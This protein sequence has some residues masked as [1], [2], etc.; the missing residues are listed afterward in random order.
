MKVRCLPAASRGRDLTHSCIPVH[1]MPITSPFTVVLEED[2]LRRVS[3]S[4]MLIG[5]LR[6]LIVDISTESVE[7]SS[8]MPQPDLVNNTPSPTYSH[9]ACKQ[10]L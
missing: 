7:T 8:D 9:T 1:Y 10:S 4:H 5:E 6:Y 2:S 3:E